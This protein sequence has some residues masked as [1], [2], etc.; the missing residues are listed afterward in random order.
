MLSY[1]PTLQ[2]QL[3][4]AADTEINQALSAA[5]VRPG[6]PHGWLTGP[7]TDEPEAVAAVVSVALPALTAAWK[8]LLAPQGLTAQIIGVFSHQSPYVTFT[9][10]KGGPQ[11]R[12]LADLL[13]VV[14]DLTG[15][16]PD[17]RAQLIQQEAELGGRPHVEMNRILAGFEILN[18]VMKSNRAITSSA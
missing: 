16:T 5:G 6:H 12:E 10:S 18:A 14:D 9:D 1:N 15:G 3:A 7:P 17:R 2:A 13:L 11:Q 8:P 4:T